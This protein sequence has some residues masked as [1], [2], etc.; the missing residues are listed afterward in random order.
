MIETELKFQVPEAQWARVR[1]AVARSD[2]SAVSMHALYFDTPERALAAARLALRLRREGSR[3]V[4]TVK[5]EGD[6]MLQRLEH[7]VEVPAGRRT[8]APDLARHDEAGPVAAALRAALGPDAAPLERVFETR[9]ERRV[10]V[11]RHA[12]AVIEIALDEGRVHAGRRERPLREIEFELKSGPV[13]ALFDLAAQWAQRHAL[14][15]DPR[16]KAERGEQL[17]QGLDALPAVKARPIRLGRD[18]PPADALA[19]M[20]G[21]SLRQILPNA[22]ELAHGHGRADHVHQLRVG[23]RRLRSALRTFA[24]MAA[25]PQQARAL[26]AAAQPVFAAL[27]GRRDLDVVRE[28]LAAP[29]HA[30]GLD[31]VAFATP[32][33]QPDAGEVVRAPAFTAFVLQALSWATDHPADAEPAA[34]PRGVQPLARKALAR[35]W[36]RIEHDALQFTAIEEEERHALRKRAKR[37]RYALEFGAALFPRRRVAAFLEALARAQDAIGAYNDAVVAEALLRTVERRDP[38][39]AFA[40]GWVAARHDAALRECDRPLRRLVRTPVP[41][42]AAPRRSR[43]SG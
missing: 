25:D 30:A 35:L 16:S 21:A 12:G 17:A 18:Q 7:E 13:A 23:L 32:Q 11:V 37:L 20:V 19:M 42:T 26:E 4:Q 41:W 6:G 36:K 15:L 39:A 31:P 24:S 1:R 40:S 29:L 5:G 33:D 38:A 9:V 27:G 22:A 43:D 10:R 34:A 8:P 14:W 28:M 3:W 2:A